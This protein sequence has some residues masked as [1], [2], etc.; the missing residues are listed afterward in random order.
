MESIFTYNRDKKKISVIRKQVEKYEQ[1]VK[2]QAEKIERTRLNDSEVNRL[3][4][5]V[6]K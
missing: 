2:E 4:K 1:L 5:E 6:E 3:Q